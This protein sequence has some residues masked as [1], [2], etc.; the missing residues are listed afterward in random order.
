MLAIAAITFSII[1]AQD[2]YA[3]PGSGSGVTAETGGSCGRDSILV[4]SSARIAKM[5]RNMDFRYGCTIIDDTPP[6][7]T[8]QFITPSGKYFCSKVTDDVGVRHVIVNGKLIKRWAGSY[9]Y[10]CDTTQN[11]NDGKINYGINSLVTRQSQSV[12]TF[13]NAH[14]EFI[15]KAWSIIAAD[16]GYN[17]DSWQPWKQ[18]SK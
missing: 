9:N 11:L 8:E 3:V 2:A 15:F 16:Y 12:I 4:T 6:K 13:T 10:Y 18:K 5:P 7:I 14:D 17:I 1:L